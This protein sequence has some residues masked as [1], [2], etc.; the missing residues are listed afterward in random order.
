M[1]KK[2]TAN[3]P[4]AA[5]AQ[6]TAPP[7]P[8]MQTPR[9]DPHPNRCTVEKGGR[10]CLLPAHHDS[11]MNPTPHHFGAAQLGDVLEKLESARRSLHD[12][13][14]LR[15][16]K[17]PEDYVM[18]LAEALGTISLTEAQAALDLEQRSRA[19]K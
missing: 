12:Y 18:A 6:P 11:S 13:A 19:N 9:R 3:K 8:E 7:A 5:K 4:T 17:V 16:P 15:C 10:R 1:A 2:K 14:S